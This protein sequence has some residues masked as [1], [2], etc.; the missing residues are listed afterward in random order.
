MRTVS[1]SKE[2][3]AYD[4][5]GYCCQRDRIPQWGS[6]SSSSRGKRLL[7]VLQRIRMWVALLLL[8]SWSSSLLVVVQAAH[9][10]RRP[11][12]QSRSS[13]SSDRRYDRSVTTFDPT[14][15]LRQVEHAWTASERGDTVVAAIV[16]ECIYV[17]TVGKQQKQSSLLWRTP[18]VQSLSMG[19]WSVTAG[20][21]GDAQYWTEQL[22]SL[23][24]Q[25][26]LESGGRIDCRITTLARLAAERQH[27]WTVTPG[28]RP[29]GLTTLLLGFLDTTTSMEPRLFR[30][31]AGG[32][33][34]DCRYC[35]MGQASGMVQ[36]AVADCYETLAVA[37]TPADVPWHY[38]IVTRLVQ[39]VQQGLGQVVLQ[40]HGHSNDE[41]DCLE[42][43]VWVF[44]KPLSV[45]HNNCQPICFTGIRDA[46]S[47][48]RVQTFW[49][50]QQSKGET[51]SEASLDR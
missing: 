46:E 22:R 36:A 17:I 7:V 38:E 14:G 6:T 15:R 5:G 40:D 33:R 4:C 2:Q 21:S 45:G 48:T 47:L 43:S 26:R 41:N 32:I 19:L 20:L 9:S 34:E 30:C 28:R 8:L 42:M 18:K 23:A 10:R 35:A 31:Q 29:L 39:A 16:G 1:E 25:Y 13:S 12:M 27:A 37:T 51:K 44:P 50:A 24:R 49:T 3:N 11:T